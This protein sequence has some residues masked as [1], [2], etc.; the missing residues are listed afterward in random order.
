[1]RQPPIALTHRLRLTIA[2]ALVAGSLRGAEPAPYFAARLAPI[3]ACS[4][5]VA[6]ARANQISLDRIDPPLEGDS[7]NP[8][9]SVTALITFREK[10]ARHT[11]WLVHVQVVAPHPEEMPDK[12]SAPMIMYTTTGSKLEF[13]SS[14]AF[15]SLR[16]LGPFAE[17]ATTRKLTKAEDKSA[18]FGLNQDFL[19]LGLDKAA[20]IARRFREDKPADLKGGFSFG[21][22]PFSESE[23]KA[24]RKLANAMHVTA[25]EE[26]ALAGTAPALMSYFGIVQRTSGL[27]DILFKILDMPSLWSILRRG[28]ISTFFHMRSEHIALANGSDWG[29]PPAQPAYHVPMVLELNN[30]PALNITL[31]VTA[32]KPPLLVCGGIVGMLAERPGDKENY[33]TLRIISAC[34]STNK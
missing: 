21:P 2:L 11:Q 34:R 33:L 14:P 13:T 1:M 30:Q 10:G 25:D 16:T 3:P 8:G 32:P 9:D 19:S 7:L 22:K 27:E 5:L 15:V 12:P 4:P 20:S 24:G 18:R 31:V 26:R 17:P 29:L 28:G 23:V 6:S